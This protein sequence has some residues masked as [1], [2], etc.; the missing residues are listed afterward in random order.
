MGRRPRRRT[1]GPGRGGTRLNRAGWSRVM[2]EQRFGSRVDN[3]LVRALIT[4]TVISL[5]TAYRALV[6]P[7][8]GKWFA[9]VIILTGVGL[10]FWV[11]RSTGSI[12]AA[13]RFPGGSGSKRSNRFTPPAA[14]GPGPNCHSTACASPVEGAG[15]C[16][17][18]RRTGTGSWQPSARPGQLL[19]SPGTAA[20]RAESTGRTVRPRGHQ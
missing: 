11:L 19:S 20:I 15:V 14:C 5:I 4:L 8:G 2:A 3:W 12:S 1:G 6:M 16:W 9:L 17:Y 13:G 18:P 7:G 10:P